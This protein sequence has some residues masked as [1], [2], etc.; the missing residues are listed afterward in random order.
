MKRV[1]LPLI[2]LLCLLLLTGSA[3]A[4]F[5]KIEAPPSVNAGQPLEVT[6]TT[7]SVNPGYTF[8]VV[9][10]N[11]GGSKSELDRKQVIVQEDGNFTIDFE[12]DDLK[13]GTYS[14]EVTP[15]GEN[16]FGGSS[17]MIKI[18]NVVNR[19]DDLTVTSP[20]SQEFDGTLTVAGKIKNYADGGVR[21]TVTGSGKKTVY[22]PT[23]ITTRQ[24]AFS[25]EVPITSGG[26]YVVEVMD[27][28]SY[29]W[30]TDF[31]VTGGIV[32]S[33]PTPRPSDE[34][35]AGAVYS[36][37]AP[38]SREAPAYFAVETRGGEVTIAT[39]SGI[40]WVLEYIDT[41]GTKTMVNERGAS[42]PESVTFD[43]DAGTVYVKVTPQ[44]YTDEGTVTVTAENVRSVAAD[45]S[46][47]GKFGDAVPEPTTQSPLPLWPVCAALALGAVLFFR[48]A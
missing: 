32:T 15:K 12:T 37:A 23:W 31:T 7:T 48:R 21:L 33:T 18:F 14:V 8:D 6:G 38:A 35:P 27:N 13:S 20:S 46:V 42:A 44:L 30:K 16:I 29:I 39:S 36:A 26:R 45:L 1:V 9:L 10:Y 2:G 24:G 40:D 28:T 47:A 19:N 11:T 41:D 22:G 5:I 4:A 17:K 25:E 34:Q 43:A 3:S